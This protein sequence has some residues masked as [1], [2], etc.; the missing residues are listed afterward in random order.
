MINRDL[1]VNTA[2]RVALLA[3]P[4]LLRYGPSCSMSFTIILSTAAASADDLYVASRVRIAT[5]VSMFT[6]DNSPWSSCPI[7]H[8]AIILSKSVFIARRK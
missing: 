7:L 8:I 3:F 1:H 4:L 6:A 5:A 2:I